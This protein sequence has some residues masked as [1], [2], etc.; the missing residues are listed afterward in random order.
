MNKIGKWIVVVLLWSQS[1]GN[2][3][4]ED[5]DCVIEPSEVADIS[6]TIRGILSSIE[7]K[8]GDWIEKGDVVARLEDSVE[9][10]SVDLAEAKAGSKKLLAARKERLDLARKRANRA[11]NLRSSK[12]I[13]SQDLDEAETD[14]AVARLE[15]EQA[16]EERRIAKLEMERAKRVLELRTIRSPL[17]GIVVDVFV[18]AGESVEDRPI[19]KV[20][21]ISPLYVEAVAPVSLFGKVSKGDVAKVKPEKPIGGEHTATVSLVE[22]IID[23]S[24]GTFGMRLILPNTDRKLPAG[25][26]C[27]LE[28]AGTAD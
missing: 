23:A 24:S 7:V 20:A 5:L 21:Q 27:R 1:T 2:L 16:Q 18:S 26:Q 10:A 28:L 22:R 14:E 11:R 19:L 9:R 15:W 25:L 8:K 12:A 17:S 3:L 4:A 13:A 6:T